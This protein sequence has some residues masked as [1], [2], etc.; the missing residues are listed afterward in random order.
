MGEDPLSIKEIQDSAKKQGTLKEYK[1]FYGPIVNDD[2]RCNA[3]VFYFKEYQKWG[4]VQLIGEL[5]VILIFA[6]FIAFGVYNYYYLGVALR[7]RYVEW[8]TANPDQVEIVQ[9]L[10]AYLGTQVYNYRFQFLLVAGSIVAIIG[11]TYLISLLVSF[12]IVRLFSKLVTVLMYVSVFIQIG[13]LLYLYWVIDWEY[14]WI[15]L[16][17][18]LP[19]ALMLIFWRDKF[20]KAIRALKMGSL[21]VADQGWNLLKPQISQT[22]LVSLLSVLFTGISFG[23]ALDITPIRDFTIEIG[24]WSYTLGEGWIY[25][26]SAVLFVI[27]IYITYYITQGMKMLMVHH[28]YRGGGKVGFWKT[29]DAIRHRWWGILGYAFSSTIIHMLQYFAKAAKGEFGPKNIKEAF[30]MTGELLPDKELSFKKKKGTPWYERVWMG[31][32]TF[33]L[34]AIVIEKKLFHSAIFRSLYLMLRDI[35]Q[36]YIKETHIKR[37]LVFL[38]YVLTVA[39]TA[40][41]GIIGWAIGRYFEFDPIVTY[42]MAAAGGALF[43]WVAGSTVTLIMDDVN[44]AYITVLYIISIDEVYNKENMYTIDRLEKCEDGQ[45]KIVV[46][47]EKRE[48]L[49]KL[50][51]E[52]EEQ[53]KKEK[54]E[55]KAKKA[56]A[57][58][59][60]EE[61]SA[62]TESKESK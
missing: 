33:T 17:L 61:T 43:L 60:K 32:N 3:G 62:I 53:K 58:E 10:W 56:K 31:I 20:K 49:E 38:Q 15:F 8:A 26:I 7:E 25:F 24:T 54:K 9:Q 44:M 35:S 23:V 6:A 29:Y 52:E 55:K 39:N 41:G 16:L 2:K 18:L 40:V 11:L 59:V 48:K 27:C 4:H 57:K 14:N 50:M 21:A 1:D 13:T 30:T 46:E 42:I 36:I 12:L 22:F 5:F 47:K 34:P 19:D 37:I 45:L 51:K 28:W